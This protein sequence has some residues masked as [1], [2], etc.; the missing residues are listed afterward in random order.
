MKILP[1]GAE[2]LQVDGRTDVTRLIAASRNF[3]NSPKTVITFVISS[4]PTSYLLSTILSVFYFVLFILHVVFVNLFRLID[5]SRFF[6][7]AFFSSHLL[8]LLRTLLHLLLFVV[9][10]TKSVGSPLAYSSPFPP[11]RNKIEN[12]EHVFHEVRFEAVTAVTE[13]VL[14]SGAVQSANSSAPFRSL[15]P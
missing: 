4:S 9:A 14:C 5:P 10:E 15:P 11:A 7:P 8:S 2:L 13:K 12:V 3:T 1:L 6:S